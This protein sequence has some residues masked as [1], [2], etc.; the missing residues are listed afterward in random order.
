MALAELNAI[1]L[2]I[3]TLEIIPISK[4]IPEEIKTI[5]QIQTTQTMYGI[6][7]LLHLDN[8]QGIFLPKRVVEH[9]TNNTK[10]LSELQEKIQE[11]KLGIKYVGTKINKTN[12]IN[13]IEFVEI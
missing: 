5:H 1:G 8:K 3:S 11:K 13:K 7:F 2:A 4:L 12:K 6:T 10:A 9:L